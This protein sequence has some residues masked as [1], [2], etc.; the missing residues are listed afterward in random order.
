MPEDPG[1]DTWFVRAREPNP[2]FEEK[3]REWLVRAQGH[4]RPP[5]EQSLAVMLRNVYEL[6]L[7]RRPRRGVRACARRRRS[8]AGHARAHRSAGAVPLSLLRRSRGCPG[9]EGGARRVMSNEKDA[10]EQGYR[11]GENSVEADLINIFDEATNEA[12]AFARVR[13]WV[14]RVVAPEAS[15]ALRARFTAAGQPPQPPAAPRRASAALG[16]GPRALRPPRRIM[17]RLRASSA[18]LRRGSRPGFHRSTPSRTESAGRDDRA[19][20]AV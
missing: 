6:G 17:R 16:N 7:S 1:G 18:A 9:G 11:D 10:Y 15:S 12:E 19:R 4:A 5:H 20:Q 8:D 2:E 14:D 3:A 13:A